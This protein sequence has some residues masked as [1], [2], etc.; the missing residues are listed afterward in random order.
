MENVETTEEI[1]PLAGNMN[2][3]VGVTADVLKKVIEDNENDNEKIADTL[4][5][6]MLPS[7]KQSIINYLE[8]KIEEV[9]TNV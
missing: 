9:V 3:L 1:I 8:G 6:M 4:L 5:M 7:L 2:L